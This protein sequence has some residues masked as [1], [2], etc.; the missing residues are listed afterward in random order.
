[1]SK[2]RKV[3]WLVAW[4]IVGL[5]TAVVVTLAQ[6]HP[7]IDAYKRGREA[8]HR[9]DFAQAQKDFFESFRKRQDP[10]TAYFLSY[11]YLR[12]YDFK[13]AD[14]WATT[15]L[16]LTSSN[17]LKQQYVDG[18]KQI[19]TFAEAMLAPPAAPS[20]TGGISITAHP[21]ILLPTPPVP[22]E[23]PRL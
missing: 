11:A 9:Q 16:E 15:T 20:S 22:D 17:S 6:D 7:A 21:F 8:F 10:L 19:K 5:M 13:N 4:T 3:G 18:A 2:Q 12:S 14:K 23:T 1:V